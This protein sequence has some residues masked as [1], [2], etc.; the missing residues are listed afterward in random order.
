MYKEHAKR[1]LD[2]VGKNVDQGIITA[3]QAANAVSVLEKEIEESRLHPTSEDVRRDIDAHHGEEGSDTEHEEVET[4][5]FAAR[6]FPLLDMLRAARDT[7]QDVVWG[8]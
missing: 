8:V 4:V 2:L 6:A 3:D 5:T 7:K 1:L